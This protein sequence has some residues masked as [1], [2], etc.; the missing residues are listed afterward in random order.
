[1][2]K[3][4]NINQAYGKKQV[5][6]NINLEIQ[7]NKIT[8]LVGANGAGKS[9]LL[10]VIARLI[11]KSS[12]KI[13][14]DNKSICEMKS[15]EISR[16]L[17]ILKQ[18]NSINISLTVKELVT[19]GRFPHSKGR[20]NKND[21]RIIDE[22]IAYMKLEDMVN[23]DINKLSGGQ[24]QRAYIA[25]ILAQDT[26]YILLD[27]PLNNLDMRHSVEMMLLLERLVKE[28]NKTIVIVVHDINIAAAFTDHIVAMKNG[29]IISEG[30]PDQMIDEKVLDNVFDHNFC[31]V[32]YQGRKM[33]VYYNGEQNVEKIREEFRSLT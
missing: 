9:T 20:I 23:D 19:F 18:Q 16:K 31:V 17:A 26:P 2:I 7:D 29:E 13:F 27:E 25:M 15:D 30:C 14:I 6:K 3:L 22:A 28:L 21:I 12:G 11:D 1:M 10:N 5:L 33:C 4:E 24:L 8:A 32:G